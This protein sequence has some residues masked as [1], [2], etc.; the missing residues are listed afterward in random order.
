MIFSFLGTGSAFCLKN[1][2]PNIL[3][4]NNDKKMLIDAG[5]DLRFSLKTLGYNYKEIDSIYISH[6]HNDHIGGMEYLA[7][8][9]YFDANCAKIHL[10]IHKLLVDELWFNSL[11]GGLG[12]IQGNTLTLKDYFD[13]HPLND[14]K[15][16]IWQDI[17]FEPIQ[18]IHVFNGSY[19]IPTF[20]LMI[21]EPDSGKIIY[22]TSDTQFTPDSQIKYYKKADIVIQDCETLKFKTGIHAHYDELKTL[23]DNIKSKLYLWHYQDN[24]VDKFNQWQNKAIN[25][26]F[27]GFIKRGK[28]LIIEKNNVIYE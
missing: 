7:F 1:Y 28:K 17:S 22:F 18:S 21:T 12:S 26:G 8:G 14:G 11:K 23:D 16:F 2:H 3:I 24:V 6:L 10:Y 19:V 20:G 13:I 27:R 25:D 9:S 15:N 5:G 4:E